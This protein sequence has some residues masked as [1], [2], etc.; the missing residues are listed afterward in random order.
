MTKERTPAVSVVVPTFQRREFVLRAVRSVLAQSFRDF[1]LV[2]VDDGSTD[3]TGEA[4]AGLDR[5]IRYLWQENRGPGAARN[6]G[7]RAA[8]GP[9]VAFLDSDDRW[10][11]GHL[12]VCVETLERFPEAVLVSTCPGQHVAGRQRPRDARIVDALPLLYGELSIG[13]PSC[14]AARRHDLIEVGGFHEGLATIEDAELYLRL[15]A[16]GPFALV[17]RRTI[18]QQITERSRHALAMEGGGV[19]TAIEAAAEAGVAVARASRR[20]DRELLLARA[21][22]K[23][24]YAAA[25]RALVEGDDVRARESLEA[26]CRLLPE[27]SR[28]PVLVARRIANVAATGA[29]ERV[30]RAAALWP[31]ARS[32][33]AAFLRLVAAA[34]AVRGGRVGAAARMLAR[35]PLAATP[36]FVLR[37]RASLVRLVRRAIRYRRNRAAQSDAA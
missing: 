7:V 13:I 17:Q 36:A 2:V 9:V 20:S 3:G 30:A 33:T 34:Y 6:A 27:L 5:R 19:L 26:A 14:V 29:A 24:R 32:D 18:V 8:S 21:E 15:A 12:A 28:S 1:E 37:N 22:G 16:R 31:D 23:V 11:P 35:R 4:L 10:L 25:V